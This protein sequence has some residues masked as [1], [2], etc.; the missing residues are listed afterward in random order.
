MAFDNTGAEWIQR[1]DRIDNPYFGA[2]MRRCGEIREAFPPS[3]GAPQPPSG[4]GHEG[5]THE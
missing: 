4:T 2:T 5:H 3:A 1:A